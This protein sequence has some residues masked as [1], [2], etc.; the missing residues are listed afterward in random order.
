[1]LLSLAMRASL[2]QQWC[3]YCAVASER[4]HRMW[5]KQYSGTYG[6][7]L[8]L[9]SFSGSFI[10][11]HT[12]IERARCAQHDIVVE[13]NALRKQGADVLTNMLGPLA[14][15]QCA[16]GASVSACILFEA[17]TTDKTLHTEA[18]QGL[19]MLLALQSK[20]SMPPS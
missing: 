2:Q 7:F 9:A 5:P 3:G 17:L 6:G 4:T 14:A 19:R 16:H 8:D 11:L 20:Q 12:R 18:L 15:C 10:F 1:M 13:M